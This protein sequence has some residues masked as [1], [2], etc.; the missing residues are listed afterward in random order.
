MAATIRWVRSTHTCAATSPKAAVAWPAHSTRAR[1]A[2]AAA[3]EDLWFTIIPF[4]CR[5]NPVRT[6]I[7]D[8]GEASNSQRRNARLPHGRKLSEIHSGEDGVAEE[9]SP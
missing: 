7:N 9:R 3:V 1:P 6:T 2:A 5:R 8:G 4:C